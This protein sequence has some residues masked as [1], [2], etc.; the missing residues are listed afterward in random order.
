VADRVIITAP[1]ALAPVR[2]WPLDGC[3]ASTPR[4][5]TV[6]VRALE[7]VTE[8]RLGASLAGWIK[9]KCVAAGIAD[10]TAVPV[11]ASAGPN[12]GALAAGD[13]R[14]VLLRAQVPTGQS[15]RR[16]IITLSLGIGT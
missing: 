10:W 2:W 13:T 7:A 12:L 3:L 11:A 16:R 8:C 14:T 1:G 4:E 5:I 15:A 9:A 6:I